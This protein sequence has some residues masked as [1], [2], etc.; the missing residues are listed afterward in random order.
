MPRPNNRFYDLLEV[1]PQ[2]SARG[3]DAGWRR[4]SER[5]DRRGSPEAKT[6]LDEARAAYE[7]LRDPT[8]R[9][10]YDGYGERGLEPGFDPSAERAALA[11][12]DARSEPR[13][14]V[15]GDPE[16]IAAYQA[17]LAAERGVDPAPAAAPYPPPG[18][19]MYGYP[20]PGYPPPGYPPPGYPPPGYPP[21][22]QAPQAAP[23]PS[24]P[25]E[26]WIPFKRAVLGGNH[27]QLIGDTLVDIP[28]TAGATSGTSV[29]VGGR[30]YILRIEEDTVFTREGLDLHCT[31]V[32]EGAQ[33]HRGGYVV[34]P[35]LDGRHLKVAMEP[36]TLDNEQ[37]VLP[38]KGIATADDIG[39]L[40]V[41]LRIRN[42]TEGLSGDGRLS[43]G[44]VTKG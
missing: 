21:Y 37:I 34:V 32:V 5:L 25:I 18:Y 3:L 9:A 24:G 14:F 12:A 2:V 42:G 23:M 4:L 19:P 33:A 44:P 43:L 1:T 16:K 13:R 39:D 36:G 10:L 8:R 38:G 27:E 20:P 22:G 28:V 31:V 26:V 6:K 35:S 15:G 29:A 7:I 41:T 17:K 40:V 30:Q 11:A